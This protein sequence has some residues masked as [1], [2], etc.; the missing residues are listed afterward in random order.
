MVNAAS[1]KRPRENSSSSEESENEYQVEAIVDK[2]FKAKKLQYLLKS[3][4]YPH[5]D[6]TGS[7]RKSFFISFVECRE[8]RALQ[9]Y[10]IMTKC[11]YFSF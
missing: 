2:R 3:K 9:V 4:G 11:S 7:F 8:N 1:K 6:N 5:A 10:K